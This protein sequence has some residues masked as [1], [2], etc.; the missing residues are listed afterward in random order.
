[1][2]LVHFPVTA[3]FEEW[4][5][6][7]GQRLCRPADRKPGRKDR[8][9]ALCDNHVFFYA[10]PC[11]YYRPGSIGNAA[12]YFAPGL[13]LGRTGSGTPFDSGALEPEPRLQPFRRNGANVDQ[14][15]K[16][17][18]KHEAPLDRWR[19]T[20]ATWLVDCY[21]EPLRYIET[22]ADRHAAGQPD[23]MTPKYLLDNNGTRGAQR[24]GRE[25]CGDRRTWTWE[26][27]VQ[28]PVSMDDIK[29]LH[30]E[31]HSF[32][33]AH[34]FADDIEARTGIRPPVRTLPIDNHQ[35]SCDALYE[36]SHDILRELTQ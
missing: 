33:N 26:I 15:W 30:V 28:Q 34:A 10:G 22:S 9:G 7:W 6:T 13:E 2:P 31:F 18:L 17:F 16:F 5:T 24:H 35:A 32:A 21:N 12:M 4:T 20:F 14:L 25:E 36:G 3:R 8:F 11:C 1:M 23:R 29:L 27:R 19:D